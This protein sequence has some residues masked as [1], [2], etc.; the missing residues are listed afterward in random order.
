MPKKVMV[1]GS[2]DIIHTG[3]IWFL[4]KAKNLCSDCKLIVVVARD[5]TIKKY[6]GRE[7]IFT[8]NER[9]EIVKSLRFVDEAVLGNELDGKTFFDILLDIKPDILVLGYDQ[10][11]PEEEIKKWAQEKGLNM[12][13]I[14]LEK[15]N[16]ENVITSSTQ[17]RKKIIKIY[18]GEEDESQKS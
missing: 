16:N 7:P 9:L 10:K 6:K 15:Y 3:H 12:D 5:S 4:K 2:F 8:E 11:V 14:R 13:I 18:C 17:A 1:A